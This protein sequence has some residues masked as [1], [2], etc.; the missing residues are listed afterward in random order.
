M[1]NIKKLFGC[2]FSLIF[3]VGLLFANP[4]TAKADYTYRIRVVLGGSG[5]ENASL[6]SDLGLQVPAGAKVAFT[7]YDENNKPIE[8]EI[9]NL[10]YNSKVTMNPSQM[11]SITPATK[12]DDNGNQVQFQKY[13]VKGVRTAG[14]DTVLHASSFNVTYDETYVVAY[15]VGEVVPYIVNYV[16]E[17]GNALV[18]PEGNGTDTIKSITCYAAAGEELY[19]PYKNIPGY[20]PNTYNYHTKSLKAPEM[21]DGTEKPFEFTFYYTKA[22]NSSNTKHTVEVIDRGTIVGDTEYSYRVVGENTVTTVSSDSTTAGDAAANEN[23]Q[24]TSDQN[25]NANVG[26]GK[27]GNV[28]AADADPKVKAKDI[29]DTPDIIEIDDDIVAKAVNPVDIYTGRSM[30]SAVIAVAA[31]L[32]LGITGF[33]A[34]KKR[35][36]L[37]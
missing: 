32:V 28:A 22:D 34:L 27:N 18:D 31:V 12:Q 2:L 16:D 24:A 7:K 21:V 1:R 15:G 5:D 29:Q 4:V 37:K 13:Y 9:S 35:K 11:V 20:Q 8:L 19:V 23:G 6:N 14:M 17:N 36:T 3:V 33:I 26:N 10:P 25:G 30:V